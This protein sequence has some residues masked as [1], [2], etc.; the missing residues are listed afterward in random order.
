MTLEQIKETLHTPA[1]DFLR[2]NEYLNDSICLLT[3]GGSYAYGTNKTDGSS[4]VDVR[5]IALNPKRDILLG[6]DFGQVTDEPTDTTIYSFNK[7][8][9]LLSDLNPNT[10]EMLGCLPEHY[11]HV[12]PIGQEILDNKKIFLSKKAIHTFGGYANQMLYRATQRFTLAFHDTDLQC[13]IRFMQ[14][15]K[16]T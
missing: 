12:S 11:L 5:G 9:K 3:L 2:N 7:M 13:C 1:Y 4:D 6:T 16:W 14:R 10:I 8:M 15:M